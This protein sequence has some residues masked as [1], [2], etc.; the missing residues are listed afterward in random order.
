MAAPTR[1]ETS[2]PQFAEYSGPCTWEEILE[3][4][5]KFATDE[6]AV[7]RFCRTDDVLNRY[8][9]WRKEVLDRYDAVAD[10]MKITVLSYPSESNPS[11]SKL[12]AITP[13]DK[14]VLSDL[15]LRLND[16]P[17]ATTPSESVL[18]YVLWSLTDLPESQIHEILS[19]KLPQYEHIFFE[20]PP[21][22]KTIPEI[23]HYHVFARLKQ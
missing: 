2:T 23:Q 11:T 20:N 7:Y 1:N 17:Y 12:R 9:D 19:S 18:H 10:Y 5:R 13:E 8:Q 6:T 21:H 22:R 14:S 15:V 3:V 16:F 4:K